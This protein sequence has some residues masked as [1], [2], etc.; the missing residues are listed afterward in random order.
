MSRASQ[1]S[2]A[3]PTQ[4]SSVSESAASE[5]S[6]ATSLPAL[7]SN[8]VERLRAQEEKLRR[9]MAE[10]ARY[11]NTGVQGARYAKPLGMTDVTKFEDNFLLANSG[12]PLYK[13]LAAEAEAPRMKD[14]LGNPVGKWR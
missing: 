13:A 10:S 7:L 9:A 11:L 3:P 5:L 1:V 8:P 6:R 2:Q 4:R 14:R 12:V